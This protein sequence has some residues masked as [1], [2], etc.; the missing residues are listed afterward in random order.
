MVFTK[1]HEGEAIEP[2]IAGI[3]ESNSFFAT[4]F[5]EFLQVS[6]VVI[7]DDHNTVMIVYSK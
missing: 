3:D 7:V 4:G 6:L 2:E 1:V 5:I